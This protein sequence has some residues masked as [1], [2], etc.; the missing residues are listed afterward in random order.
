M[1]DTPEVEVPDVMGMSDEDFL[2]QDFSEVEFNVEEA[3]DE[4][5]QETEVEETEEETSSE[6]DGEEVDEES[7]DETEEEGS[8]ETSDDESDATEETDDE[9]EDEESEGTDKSEEQDASEDNPDVDTYKEQIDSLFAPIKANGKEHTI[10]DIEEARKL[11]SMGMGFTKKMEKL[12]PARL[13]HKKMQEHNLLEEGKLDYLIAL[14]KK[15]P[16]A[17]TQLLKDAKIDPLNIDMESDSSYQPKT[18]S[19]GEDNLALEDVITELESSDY[20]DN[21][22]DLISNKW[23]ESSKQILR[24]SPALLH[25]I[26]SH[27]SNGIYDSIMQ[28]VDK[29]KMLGNYMGVSDVVAYGQVAEVMNSEGQFD[30]LKPSTQTVQEDPKPQTIK[31]AIKPKSAK[32]DP[33]LKRKKATA[34]TK[35]KP[36]K[37]EPIKDYLNMSDEDFLAQ[38]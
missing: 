38:G 15:D 9:V 34:V 23:G 27:M 37:K 26:E 17:I 14:D 24:E 8:E 2:A 16:D 36:V 25:I 30:H 29:E 10:R 13:L 11:I 19:G 3:S 33:N 20:A 35:S 4:Q 1:S 6:L 22:A 12:K 5:E 7:E 21:L 18:Y 31:R 28:R 32:P